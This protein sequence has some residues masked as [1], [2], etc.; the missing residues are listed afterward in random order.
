MVDTMDPV[1]TKQE[2]LTPPIETSIF[3]QEATNSH[4]A[5]SCEPEGS[6]PELWLNSSVGASFP[7]ANW[8]EPA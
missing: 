4:V 3:G 2:T 6:P 1:S 5:T 8:A 7:A